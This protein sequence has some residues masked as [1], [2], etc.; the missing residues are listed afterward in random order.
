MVPG[1]GSVF[2]VTLPIISGFPFP[3][4][5]ELLPAHLPLPAKI[6]TQ[7]LEP[8]E[9]DDDPEREND[10]QYVQ[11]IYNEVERVLQQGVND[12]AKKRRLP[13]FL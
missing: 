9:L 3:V 2:R 11:Q 8:I 13:V 7:L 10:K 4:A 6:R 5:V 1:A 12:L